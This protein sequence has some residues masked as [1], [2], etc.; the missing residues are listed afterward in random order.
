MPGVLWPKFEDSVVGERL[1]FTGA[2][3]DD[4]LDT[5]TLAARL[6]QYLA[7]SYPARLAERFR[8]E[9][10]DGLSGYALLEAVGRKR[11]MLVSGGEVNTER[12]AAAVLEEYR[13][14]KLG[15]ITL[16]APPEE[17]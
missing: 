10:T 13:S 16:E 8:L 15:R 2:I 1:A 14:G 3:K 12:A 7:G 9:K 5:E 4:V 11:G 6:L 17:S